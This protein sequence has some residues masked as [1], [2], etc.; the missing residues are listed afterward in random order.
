MKPIRYSEHAR[1]KTAARGVEANDVARI[2]EAPL[3]RETEPADPTV[4]R[5]FGMVG[6]RVLRI[7]VRETPN[8]TLIVTAVFDRGA[9]RRLTRGERP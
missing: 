5:R 8:E 7:A 1:I 3:W 4:E 9:R 2:V 6:E